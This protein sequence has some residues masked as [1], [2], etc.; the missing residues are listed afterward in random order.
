VKS[1][2]GEVGRAVEIAIEAGYRHI[3]TAFAYDNEEEIGQALARCFARGIVKRE[4][5]FVTT[6]LWATFHRVCEHNK[7]HFGLFSYVYYFSPSRKSASMRVCS[8]L[9]ASLASSTSTS[10]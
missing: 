6:K 7:A 3:D 4:D 10:T 9:F 5:I 1:T 8:G 2:K